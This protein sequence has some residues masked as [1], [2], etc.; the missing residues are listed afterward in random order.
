M[1]MMNSVYLCVCMYTYIHAY[2]GNLRCDS[3]FLNRATGEKVT[4]SEV[5]HAFRGTDNKQT[6][7]GSW[8]PSATR[9]DRP[10]GD[11]FLLY[12]ANHYPIP[13]SL[14]SPEEWRRVKFQ[15]RV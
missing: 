14:T 6:V 7:L 13:Y 12:F 4:V 3:G 1:M 9:E 10:K 11:H 15:E 8:G 5:F 2:V